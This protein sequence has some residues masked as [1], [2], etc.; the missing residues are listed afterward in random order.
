MEEEVEA[1]AEGMEEGAA[2]AD[3]GYADGELDGQAD[4]GAEG[5]DVV[6]AGQPAAQAHADDG[7]YAE[8]EAEVDR[9]DAEAA[10]EERVVADADADSAAGIGD[11]GADA[12]VY[13]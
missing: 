2:A 9:E 3:G 1:G 11:G 6:G 12:D 4:M 10:E 7:A 5:C 8:V 13:A